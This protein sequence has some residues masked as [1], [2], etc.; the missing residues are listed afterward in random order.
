[1]TD[2]KIDK[3]FYIYFFIIAGFLFYGNTLTNK[4]ALDD[5]IVITQNKFTKQGINGIYDILT[6]EGFTG[7]FG[8]KK[9]LVAGGRY[10]PLSLVS[11][12][13]EYQFFGQNPFISHLI[14]ILLYILT[15]ILL[16]ITL[17]EL[18]PEQN[19]NNIFNI[20]FVASLIFLIH[21]IHT[22]V[23][24]NI[25]GR[26]E[27]MTLLGS[28]YTL[29]LSLKYLKNKE[30]KTLLLI[31][32]VFF[33]ALMSKENA[34][35]FLAIVPLSVYYFKKENLKNI[36]PVMLAMSIASI[37]YLIIRFNVIGFA[38]SAGTHEL[39][40]NPY[41]NA[42]TAD[43]YATIFY[44]ML[45]YIKLLI[46]PHPLTFDYYPKQ[47]P[48][49]SWTDIRAIAGF[50]VYLAMFIY[51][52]V[53]LKKR[54]KI[55]YSIWFYLISFSVVSNLVFNVGTFM[56][57]RF[58]YISSIGFAIILAVICCKYIKNIR[59]QASFLIIIF[60]LAQIKTYTRNKAWENDYILFTTDVKTSS[61]SAKSNT[62]AG[63]KSIEIV[64]KLK[65]IKKEH[66]QGNELHKEINN[67][68]LRQS[69]KNEL[70][71][72]DIYKNI[73]IKIK[74]LQTQALK[75]L[76]KAVKIHPTYNDALL[77]LGNARFS[78]DNKNVE[79]VWNAYERI[80]KTTPG[81]SK[82][83]ENLNII[84]NDSIPAKTR[85]HIWSEAF[86]YNPNNFDIN[87]NLGHLYGKF[88][89]NNDT[90][91]YFLNRAIQLN[92]KD[93]R[94]FKDLGVAFGI[95]GKYKEALWAFNKA[96]E[97][98]PD[99]EQ[100]LQNIGITYMQ[101][102]DYKNAVNIFGKILNKNPNSTKALGNY[103][104]A[105]IYA[106]MYDKALN[107]LLPMYK[108]NPND[109]SVNYNLA[110]IYAKMGDAKQSNF[111]YANTQKL[112]KH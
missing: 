94:A 59:V 105:L 52:V 104:N 107:I 98:K 91:L 69:E 55:S 60:V 95:S 15:S 50:I 49:I 62:S 84:L 9:D 71:T 86:K 45:L 14:N 37:I 61:E 18:F 2:I 20:P 72:G 88:M 87:Y 31:A 73:N 16:F 67:L 32:I 44:T 99:D 57:E 79:A 97:L 29:Y 83:Y 74:K 82:V 81:F 77:L 38:F 75:Y 40:N 13:L 1:M 63:G 25:K 90:A 53:G 76:E 110:V 101:V 7:F 27:I 64:D 5:A 109:F 24:A 17:K 108:Q 56:N 22:E 85:I 34:I 10:R 48:I 23:V 33:L 93:S 102:K 103:I 11:F 65:K 35:T 41:V 12:A 46:L 100:L 4:Y 26:D 43:K 58:M 28:V 66:P 78:I 80:L 42:S 3:R 51:A 70:L 96:Y 89:G 19:N 47:I 39:M 54:D 21:P 106:Q 92:P 30:I 6:N 111:Y 112:K 36:I 8:K 68:D